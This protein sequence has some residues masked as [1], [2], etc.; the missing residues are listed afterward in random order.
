MSPNFWGCRCCG[1]SVYDVLGYNLDGDIVRRQFHEHGGYNLE[2]GITPGAKISVSADADVVICASDTNLSVMDNDRNGNATRLQQGW[3]TSNRIL[4]GDPACLAGIAEGRLARGGWRISKKSKDGDWWASCVS[5]VDNQY[6]TGKIRISRAWKLSIAQSLDSMPAYSVP[7]GSLTN[8]EYQDLDPSPYWT[9]WNGLYL[10]SEQFVDGT[11]PQSVIGGEQ[12]M[13]GYYG[14]SVGNYAS[15]QFGF[16]GKIPYP[17]LQT[18][19]ETYQHYR[20]GAMMYYSF[21]FAWTNGLPS[22]DDGP[23]S[24]AESDSIE[25]A[26][27]VSLGDLFRRDGEGRDANVWY[28]DESSEDFVDLDTSIASVDGTQWH[29]IRHNYFP[30]GAFRQKQGLCI[31]RELDLG[32]T[33]TSHDLLGDNEWPTLVRSVSNPFGTNILPKDVFAK[34]GYLYVLLPDES[35]S[36]YWRRLVKIDISD[37]SVVWTKTPPE[38]WQCFH[39]ITLDGDM[40]WCAVSA[41]DGSVFE[42]P[43]S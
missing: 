1:G 5:V 42:N 11:I 22:Y 3:I 31:Y 21:P 26:A 10:Q 17:T 16:S 34:D 23:V 27:V 39:S 35:D 24:H 18:E 4:I 32:N 7:V 15:G 28:Y 25:A 29:G 43:E 30:S 13:D 2:A 41:S 20:G 38:D 33:Q 36:R 8:D 40:L 6:G 19:S 14:G 37:F 12:V 9:Y